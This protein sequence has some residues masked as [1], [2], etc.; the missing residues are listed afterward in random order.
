MRVHPP[1]PPAPPTHTSP[2]SY[3]GEI[4]LLC[5]IHRTMTVRAVTMGLV[6]VIDRRHFLRLMAEYPAD[7]TQLLLSAALRYRVK[8]KPGYVVDTQVSGSTASAAIYHSLTTATTATAKKA[9]HLGELGGLHLPQFQHGLA[10]HLSAQLQEGSSSSDRWKRRILSSASSSGAIGG[11][12]VGGGG[13]TEQDRAAHSKKRQTSGGMGGGLEERSARGRHLSMMDATSPMAYVSSNSDEIERLKIHSR[14]VPITS[15]AADLSAVDHDI[16]IVQMLRDCADEVSQPAATA[17]TQPAP[18]PSDAGGGNKRLSLRRPSAAA[19]MHNA[20]YDQ[21][22]MKLEE[23]LEDDI[24]HEE[25]LVCRSTLCRSTFACGAADATQFCN[26]A[27][28]ASGPEA[29]DALGSRPD[30]AVKWFDSELAC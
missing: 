24:E 16:Q 18:P 8:P 5:A 29:E 25:S 21:N 27:S 4:A 22:R 9:L 1:I 28:C 7:R 19:F 6:F 17:A 10:R 23:A 30:R 12:G 26:G 15:S 2:G 11:G 20:R 13:G 3:F 14:L